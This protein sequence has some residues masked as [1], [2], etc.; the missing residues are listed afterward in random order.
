M[1]DFLTHS[2]RWRVKFWNLH[3][4]FVFEFVRLEFAWTWLFTNGGVAHIFGA[5]MNISYGIKRCQE[6]EY[7][8]TFTSTGAVIKVDCQDQECRRE[9]EER[10]STA[11]T[12]T[13]D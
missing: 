13:E 12:L 8:S 2:H 1:Y 9:K 4:E 11:A 5:S 7:I 3:L 6:L 10:I